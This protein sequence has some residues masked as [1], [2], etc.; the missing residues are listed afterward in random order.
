MNYFGKIWGPL[1]HKNLR[2]LLVKP[3][4]ELK[5]LIQKFPL[6]ESNN[7]YKQ[8]E[9]FPFSLSLSSILFIFILPSFKEEVGAFG[10][11]R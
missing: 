1:D 8:L 3:N 2:T 5:S 9:I 6:Q 7:F 4:L 11:L 10:S